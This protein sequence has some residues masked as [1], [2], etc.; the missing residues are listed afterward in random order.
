MRLTEPGRS[1]RARGRR[2]MLA[3]AGPIGVAATNFFLSFSMLRLDTPDAFGTFSFL[4]A[5][6]LFTIALSAALFGAPM[7]AHHADAAVDRTMTVA[8]V[9]AAAVV[10]A[11]I[12][13]PAFAL[14]GGWL[15]LMPVA[16]LCYGAFAMLT[17]LRCLGRAWCF[18]IERPWAVTLSDAS[19]AVVTLGTFA[20]LS[21]GGAVPER[22]VYP[23]LALG[24][25]AAVA[26]LGGRFAA[27]LRRP[28]WA[29]L[30]GYGAIWQSQSRWSLLGVTATEATANAHIYL[31]TLLAGPATVAPVAASALL[32][33][34]INV[35]QN[36]LVE[37]ERPQIAR[38]LSAGAVDD[39]GRSVRLFRAVLLVVWAGSVAMAAAILLVSPTLIFPA[40][41]D[42]IIVRIGVALWSGV[43]LM[44]LWQ[45]P[46]NVLLQAGG[47]FRPLAHAGVVAAVVSVGGV[48]IVIALAAPIWTIAAIGLGW[49]ASMVV[50]AR[51]A[52]D[53]RQSRLSDF[54]I[55]PAIDAAA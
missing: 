31:L 44:I 41:Y 11:A 33:R 39:V 14:L 2:Y 37:Y 49:L 53:F 9:A 8:S 40:S 3:A 42:P 22:A 55:R 28:R 16:A 50:V 27:L 17:I 54:G 5:A 21:V 4:F 34:P 45:V 20:G 24:T 48:L 26:S 36:A 30:R 43:S 10:G 15:G 13:G 23:A 19:Y 7:Q 32:L 12:A 46:L 25:A 52:R 29:A 51:A 35:I 1:Y 18:A 6:A 47:E 38:F